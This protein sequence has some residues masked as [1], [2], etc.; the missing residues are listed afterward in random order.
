MNFTQA[1]QKLVTNKGSKITCPAWKEDGY[2][3]RVCPRLKSLQWFNGEKFEPVEAYN[4]YYWIVS[5][6]EDWTWEG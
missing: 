3:V 4:L 5:K 1:L 6:D 2:Y